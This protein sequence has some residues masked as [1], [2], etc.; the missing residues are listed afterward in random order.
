MFQSTNQPNLKIYMLSGNSSLSAPTTFRTFDQ[1]TVQRDKNSR[2]TV[3]L[4]SSPVQ[5][6]SCKNI[7]YPHH[8][9]CFFLCGVHMLVECYIIGRAVPFLSSKSNPSV[10]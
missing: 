4:P 3:K 9:T 8:E 10:C 7:A 2:G 5:T 1:P 6:S